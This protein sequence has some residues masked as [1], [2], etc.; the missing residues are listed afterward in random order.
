MELGT[1]LP[2][3]NPALHEAANT[4]FSVKKLVKVP[5]D[6]PHWSDTGG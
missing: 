3:K 4:Y 6:D 5:P 2:A 1:G